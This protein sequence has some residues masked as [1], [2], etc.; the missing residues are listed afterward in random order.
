M[1]RR[2]VAAVALLAAL[3]LRAAGAAEPPLTLVEPYGPGSITDRFAQAMKPG[4]EQ[5]MGRTVTVEHAGAEPVGALAARIAA[6]PHDG[7][8]VFLADLLNLELASAAGKSG[9]NLAE[10]TPIAKLSG[11]G[12]VSLVVAEA[13]PIKSWADFAAAAAAGPL[14]IAHIGRMTTTGVPLAL[15]EKVLGVQFADVVAASRADLLAALADKRAAAGF[16]VTNML[17]PGPDAAPVRA[18]VSFGAARS[19]ALPEVPT[20]Q[21]AAHQRKAA[22]TTVIA[23]FGPGGLDD[24]TTRRL[25]SSFAAAARTALHADP[26]G[27]RALQL[28]AGANW[29]LRETMERDAR[30]IRSLIDLQH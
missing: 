2:L 16:L 17:Q 1:R 18:I 7:S 11:A 24:R 6:A 27:S 8:V 4:L 30:V 3:S 10:L 21:E 28:R 12:S 9:F 22:I 29:L 25:S 13:S 14:A 23:V 26:Q 20:F 15:M 19:P 5:A